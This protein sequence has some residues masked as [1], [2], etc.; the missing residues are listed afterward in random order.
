MPEIQVF[1]VSN[2]HLYSTTLSLINH[3]KAYELGNS[4]HQWRPSTLKLWRMKS[5]IRERPSFKCSPLAEENVLNSSQDFGR[6]KI[7]WQVTG[8]TKMVYAL[9]SVG[10]PPLL[11]HTLSTG[12]QIMLVSYHALALLPTLNSMSCSSFSCQ[13][14]RIAK[15]NKFCGTGSD[16][17]TASSF[18]AGSLSS[19][20]SLEDDRCCPMMILKCNFTR[21]IP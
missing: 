3:S 19:L 6:S 13:A 10:V 20:G 4:L 2:F 8:S 5:R 15:N 11:S 18:W 12:L 17:K 9:E 1:Q 14:S 16:S 7:W 21:H